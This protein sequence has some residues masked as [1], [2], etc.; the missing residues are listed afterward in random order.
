MS[1]NN[2]KNKTL[3]SQEARAIVKK[4]MDAYQSDPVT[5]KSYCQKYDFDG[6]HLCYNADFFTQLMQLCLTEDT[7]LTQTDNMSTL[8]IIHTMNDQRVVCH[9]TPGGFFLSSTENT[10][11]CKHPLSRLI[12]WIT[13]LKMKPQYES[14]FNSTYLNMLNADLKRHGFVTQ[15]CATLQDMATAFNT[16]LC[17]SCC[18]SK[19]TKTYKDYNVLTFNSGY[20]DGELRRHPKDK[21]GCKCNNFDYFLQLLCLAVL[22]NGW[23]GDSY[24]GQT[25]LD[26]CGEELTANLECGQDLYF[27]S[28]H[29]GG[30]PRRVF[31]SFLD[32]II[33]NN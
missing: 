13:L 20:Y 29:V 6:H 4:A 24:D 17:P 12:F 25:T 11:V 21:T 19:E 23:T 16:E 26:Y 22:K 30:P 1:D 14:A 33:S 28:C 2:N 27:H 8:A 10:G 7:F 15:S 31:R 3:T 18:K 32:L 9:I 5:H